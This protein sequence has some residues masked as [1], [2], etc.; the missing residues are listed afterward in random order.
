MRENPVFLYRQK[1]KR[2][3]DMN[4]KNV[5][6]Y[7]RTVKANGG[8]ITAEVLNDAANIF[9]SSY[10]EYMRIYDALEVLLWQK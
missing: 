2:E 3:G 7:L 1:I 10:E 5:L 4:M 6:D 8:K 9:S